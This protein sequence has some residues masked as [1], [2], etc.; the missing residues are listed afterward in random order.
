MTTCEVC[1]TILGDSPE[2]GALAE[3]PSLLLPD[4]HDAES[5]V[6]KEIHEKQ[7]YRHR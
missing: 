6:S 3:L 7:N 1:G 2:A 5:L 4:Q